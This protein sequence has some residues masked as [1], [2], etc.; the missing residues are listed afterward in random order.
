MDP[1]VRARRIAVHRAEGPEAVD[2][3]RDRRRRSCSCSSVPSP[4]SASPLFDVRTIDVQGAEYTDPA[5]CRRSSTS[6][7]ARR[8]CSSTP[9]GRAPAGEQPVGRVG[10]G[11]DRL[12]PR[13]SS[14]SASASR[15]RPSPARTASSASSTATG[16][17]SPWSAAGRS[18]TCWSPV[19]SPTSSRGQFAGRPFAAAAQLAIALPGEIRAMTTSIGV[20]ATTG[21]LSL[22]LDDD[23]D[24]QLGASADLSSQAGPPARREVRGR[25]RR[26][27]RARRV[28][29]GDLANDVLG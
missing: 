29:L 3:G 24:V 20:D 2:L 23:A 25:S 28:D 26:H 19:P 14:T 16:G 8:S 27:L 11:V 5:Q 12:P 9:E 21:E 15:S 22:E 10:A 1:R 18:T 6:S 7:A 17:C 13:C 4:C